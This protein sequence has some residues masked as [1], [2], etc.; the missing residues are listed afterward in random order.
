MIEDVALKV[1]LPFGEPALLVGEGTM[2]YPGNS[3][4]LRAPDA[5]ETVKETKLGKMRLPLGEAAALDTSGLLVAAICNGI[6]VVEFMN[7]VAWRP[8]VPCASA[9]EDV[10]IDGRVN[11]GW[12]EGMMVKDITEATAVSPGEVGDT[13]GLLGGATHLVQSVDVEVRVTVEMVVVISSNDV[14][15]EVTRLVIGQVVKVV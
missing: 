8:P 1:I 5:A 12:A 7:M 15:P 9:T 2:L 6:T 3:R 4:V 14:L 13:A 11:E 10:E